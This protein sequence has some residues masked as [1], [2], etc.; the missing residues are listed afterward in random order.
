M[1]YEVALGL[2]FFSWASGYVLGFKLRQIADAL[3]AI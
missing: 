2:L 1:G 3:T